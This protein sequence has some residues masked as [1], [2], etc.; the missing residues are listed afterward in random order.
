VDVAD[1]QRRSRAMAHTAS[2]RAAVRFLKKPAPAEHTLINWP[3]MGAQ[4]AL[5]RIEAVTAVRAAAIAFSR[6]QR[7]A[8]GPCRAFGGR[9]AEIDAETPAVPERCPEPPEF[10]NS[11]ARDEWWTVAPQLHALGLLTKLD[12]ATLAAYCS[13]Y[14][15]WRQASE[16]L[17]RLAA[18]DPATHGQLIRTRGGDAVVNPL[19]S[20]A[21]KHAGD[22]IK[23][24]AEFGLTA[25][26]RSRIG[27]AGYEPPKESKF[28]GLIGGTI[29][30]MKRGD[31]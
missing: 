31:E 2:W 6:T 3:R 10:L 27:A 17:A 26:A 21:R 14:S 15:H 30:S 7:A 4:E 16:S 24:A 11:Y 18:N 23:F 5:Q 12:C 8:C 9:G 22:T 20:I 28:T 13:A 1:V 25:A 19:L 29:V